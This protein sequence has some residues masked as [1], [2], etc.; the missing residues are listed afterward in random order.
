VTSLG[1]AAHAD[2]HRTLAAAGVGW[3]VVECHAAV[4]GP[5]AERSLAA[6]LRAVSAAG[7][8]VVCL[9]RGGGARTDLAAFDA[10]ELARTIAGLE[11]PVLT[12]VGHEVDTSVADAVAW[13]RHPTPTAC[14]A[15]LA[16]RVARWCER[17]DE[18]LGRCVAAA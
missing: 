2:V 12:G 10:E 11:V 18:L 9:V 16:D 8:D 7:V 3:Q 6:A 15:W 5:G 4:Q 17:R 14:A 13:R 1:S